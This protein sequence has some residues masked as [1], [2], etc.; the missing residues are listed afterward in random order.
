MAVD[1]PPVGEEVELELFEFRSEGP[2]LG[3]IDVEEDFP[4]LFD[5][6]KVIPGYDGAAG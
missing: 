3:F 6:R 5:E 4:A 2:R 1:G